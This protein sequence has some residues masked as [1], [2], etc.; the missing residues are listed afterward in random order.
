[1][2]LCMLNLNGRRLNLQSAHCNVVPLPGLKTLT[3]PW[4]GIPTRATSRLS[5]A[6][7][8][9][10]ITAP[11]NHHYRPTTSFLILPD[12]REAIGPTCQTRTAPLLLN[13]RAIPNRS[14]HP[15]SFFVMPCSFSAP[16]VA[17]PSRCELW[18][19]CMFL[20]FLNSL[21]LFVCERSPGR[22]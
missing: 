20:W 3:L 10:A 2:P 12:D 15:P 4:L 9:E 7:S 19:E 6:W 17:W 1:M 18:S 14:K 11:L 21:W 22:F 5:R 8:G 16:F 13:R